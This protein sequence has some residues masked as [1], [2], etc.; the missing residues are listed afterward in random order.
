MQKVELSK[1]G[2]VDGEELKQVPG[3]GCFSRIGR[4]VVLHAVLT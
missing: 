2:V 1:F 3:G 4:I